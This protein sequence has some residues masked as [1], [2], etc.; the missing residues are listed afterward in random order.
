MPDPLLEDDV[1]TGSTNPVVV[2]TSTDDE[3]QNVI[4]INDPP[5]PVDDDHIGFKD[6]EKTSGIRYVADPHED[7]AQMREDLETAEIEEALENK[8][9]NPLLFLGVV[10]SY[11]LFF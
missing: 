4:P 3:L 9:L 11:F 7:Q 5:D 2:D 10:V 8:K 6:F 1:R